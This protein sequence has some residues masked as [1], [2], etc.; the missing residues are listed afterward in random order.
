M[1]QN[2]RGAIQW[3]K[4]TKWRASNRETQAVVAKQKA[5]H[6]VTSMRLPNTGISAGRDRLRGYSAGAVD[7]DPG[8]RK[9][10]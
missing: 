8:P 7:A 10:A 9:I 1:V 3:D 2:R 6:S 5:S 4:T